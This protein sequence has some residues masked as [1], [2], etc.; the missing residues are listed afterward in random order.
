MI[1][2]SDII[3]G[4]MSKQH[5]FVRLI[6][7]RPTFPMDMT[8]NEKKLMQEHARYTHAGFQA[9]KVLIYGPVMARGGAFG[10]AVFEVKD[11]TELRQFMENDPTVRAGLNRFEFHPMRVAAAQ[12][13][14]SEE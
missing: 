12:G 1:L 3:G 10:M 9:G 8:D 5:F 13:F 2:E 7:P 6:A 14:G 4:A 11:E